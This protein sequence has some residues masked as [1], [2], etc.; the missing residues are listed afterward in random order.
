LDYS[1]NSLLR[2]GLPSYSLLAGSYSGLVHVQWILIINRF[3][4]LFDLVNIVYILLNLL[5]DL[6]SI[7]VIQLLPMLIDYFGYLGCALPWSFLDLNT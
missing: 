4:G 1:L 5:D 2:P 6:A 3:F 7:S